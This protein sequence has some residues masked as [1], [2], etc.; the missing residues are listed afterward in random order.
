MGSEAGASGL[1]VGL[2]GRPSRRSDL[3]GEPAADDRSRQPH[4]VSLERVQRQHR[5]RLRRPDQ[6]H[7]DR[8]HPGHESRHLLHVPLFQ[9]RAARRVRLEHPRG[10]DSGAARLGRDLL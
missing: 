1:P 2:H 9:G 7:P 3:P 8:R 6:R 5:A 10:W 4:C